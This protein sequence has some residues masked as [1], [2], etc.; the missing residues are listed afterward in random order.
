MRAV[1]SPSSSSAIR[2]SYLDD[3]ADDRVLLEAARRALVPGGTMTLDIVDGSW[4][5]A[6]LDERRWEWIDDQHLVCRERKLG[7][8]SAIASLPAN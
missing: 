4:F 2:S 6:H 7:P 5:R 3:V 1:R 8:G